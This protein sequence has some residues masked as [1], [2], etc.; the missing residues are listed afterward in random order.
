MVPRMRHRE[1]T[2]AVLASVPFSLSVKWKEAFSLKAPKKAV[3][4][5]LHKMF[6]A[7][8]FL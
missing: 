1:L 5:S 4:P 8:N 7:K 3:I 6:V 2:I